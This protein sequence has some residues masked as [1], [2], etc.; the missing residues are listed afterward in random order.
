METL[1]HHHLFHFWTVVREHGVTRASEKLHVSQ[2][3]ISGQLRELEEALG[4]KNETCMSRAAA[5]LAKRVAYALDGNS[6]DGA[7]ASGS[8]L[9]PPHRTRSGGVGRSISQT[10]STIP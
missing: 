7:R 10:A 5:R 3:T 6:G 4:E 1:N 2:P 8:A 9:A